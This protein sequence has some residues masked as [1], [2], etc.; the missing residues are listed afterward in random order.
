MR[1]EAPPCLTTEQHMTKVDVNG[2]GCGGAGKI[3]DAHWALSRGVAV[4]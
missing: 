1:W 3:R 2:M 4:S